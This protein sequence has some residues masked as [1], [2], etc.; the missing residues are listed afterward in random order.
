MS[1]SSLNIQA[2]IVNTKDNKEKNLSVTILTPNLG[3]IY[4]Y[5]TGA[6]SINSSRSANL[7]LGNIVK[8][9]LFQKYNSYWITECQSTL[10]F[11]QKDHQL[12]Q[13]NLLFYFLEILKNFA[14]ENEISLKLFDLSSQTITALYNNNWPQFIKKQIEILNTLGFGAPADLQE[15]YINKDYQ[16]AQQ[17]LIIYFESILQ[18]PLASHKLLTK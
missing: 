17:Q 7:Q 1:Q 2:I 18:K 12:I 4:A 6:K 10:S 11:L 15:N 14:P 13:L 9:S 16:L 3:K 8:I 5:A